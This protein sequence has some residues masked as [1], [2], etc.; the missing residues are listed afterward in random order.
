MLRKVQIRWTQTRKTFSFSQQPMNRT[1]N[2]H[3]RERN[4]HQL[5][6]RRIKGFVSSWLACIA[7]FC[8]MM[9]LWQHHP[10]QTV[11]RFLVL[12]HTFFL[13]RKCVGCSLLPPLSSLVRGYCLGCSSYI[14]GLSHFVLLVSCPGDIHLLC[15]RP[16]NY[17]CCGGLR[18]A[19]PACS[20]CPLHHTYCYTFKL[21]LSLKQLEMLLLCLYII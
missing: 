18:P 17:W 11:C 6:I 4:S 21:Y 2:L 10:G 16:M 13:V 15:T 9:T 8:C 3:R 19:T 12:P 7:Y 5:Q 14:S 1:M 20:R